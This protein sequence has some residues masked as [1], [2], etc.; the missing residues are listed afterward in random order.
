MKPTAI[1]VPQSVTG[2]LAEVLDSYART[3]EK[4]N[5]RRAHLF[6]AVIKAMRECR[7]AR[8]RRRWCPRCMVRKAKQERRKLEERFASLPCGADLFMI[9]LTV[10]A[11]SLRQG[12][13][14]L[15]E[16]FT[17]LRR[18]RFWTRVVVGGS[19]HMQMLPSKGGKRRWNVHVHVI[20]ELQ[21]EQMLDGGELAERWAEMLA[22]HGLPGSA[23]IRRVRK[24]WATH[25]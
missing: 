2:R 16:S 23:R 21:K 11:D 24:L 19:Q 17:R 14:V 9:T 3:D 18:L 12:W 6:R 8:C 25:E 10:G 22:R 15:R 13:R 7:E 4:D 5:P 1:G 20:V